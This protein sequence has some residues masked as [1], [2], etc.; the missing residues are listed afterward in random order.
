MTRRSLLINQ[1]TLYLWLYRIA[2]M[3]YALLIIV[4]IATVSFG[5]I[6]LQ[7]SSLNSFGSV[8]SQN[9]LQLSQSVGQPSNVGVLIKENT[10]ILH[11]GFQQPFPMDIT[12][13]QFNIT[14][15][16]NPNNGK[17]SLETDTWLEGEVRIE[18]FDSQGRQ[19]YST[20]FNTGRQ[21]KITSGNF[22]SGIYTLRI[23]NNMKTTSQKLIIQTQ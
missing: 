23:S 1:F 2:T 22:E 4:F 21:F 12:S 7:R 13:E 8:V 5:Q 18:L 15:Y 20:V 6:Q 17:F 16:P 11:Q 3:K 9:D 10:G 19:C 14:I